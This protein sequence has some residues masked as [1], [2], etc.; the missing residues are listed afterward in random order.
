MLQYNHVKI[1]KL[2]YSLIINDVE[3]VAI[4]GQAEK[5]KIEKKKNVYLS[6]FKC[7]DENRAKE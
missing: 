4:K 6:N 3:Y 7:W 2:S 5:Y 1:I